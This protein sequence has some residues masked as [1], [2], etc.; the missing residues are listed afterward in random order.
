M[1]KSV[2]I[3]LII[4]SLLFY[5]SF[6]LDFDFLFPNHWATIVTL[7]INPI[8]SLIGLIPAIWY[9]RWLSMFGL[10]IYFFSFPIAMAAGYLLEAFKV[11]WD[12]SPTSLY[13]V[14]V[15]WIVFL[16]IALLAYLNR[17][18]ITSRLDKI[19]FSII[20]LPALLVLIAISIY[21]ATHF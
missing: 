5:S 11:G 19:T 16:L 4:E 15:L 2:N 6:V 13:V 21:V 17:H 18:K 12:I 9:K 10:I 1:K 8:L 7:V 20:Y 3:I 14:M